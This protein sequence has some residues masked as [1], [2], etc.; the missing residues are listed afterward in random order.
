MVLSYIRVSTNK[1]DGDVQKLQIL[2]YCN[3]NKLVVDEFMEVEISSKKSEEERKI[4]LLHEKLK[5]DDTLIVVELS[6]LGRDMLGVTNLVID[7][8]QKGIFIIFIRQPYLSTNGV[9]S[10]M[11]KYLFATFGY[12]AETERDFISDRTKAGLAKAREKGIKLG[13]PFGSKS[14]MYD[15]DYD[16]IIRLLEKDLSLSSIWK[17]LNRK[18]SFENFYQ[19]CKRR[20][21]LKKK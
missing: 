3:K 13:R 10:T 2:E 4:K 9:P 17:F 20:K 21:L 18:G 5:K 1:Q 11:K 8:L 19:Y 12:F 14:S 7:L 16:E 6:R 15:E